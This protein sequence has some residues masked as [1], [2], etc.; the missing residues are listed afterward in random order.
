M[1]QLQSYSFRRGTYASTIFSLSFGPSLL[2]PDILA[3]TSSSGS[4]HVFSPGIAVNQR[5]IMSLHIS[6][7]SWYLLGCKKSILD[8][9]TSDWCLVSYRKFL[10]RISYFNKREVALILERLTINLVNLIAISFLLL[11]SEH[12]ICFLTCFHALILIVVHYFPLKFL[13]NID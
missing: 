6:N 13:C 11:W 3:A 10:S 5:W 7:C 2:L 9:N 1:L 4:V 12:K 8:F